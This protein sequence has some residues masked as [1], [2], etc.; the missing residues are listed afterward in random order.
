MTATRTGS[1]SECES[2]LSEIQSLYT[3]ISYTLIPQG[4]DVWQITVT[5]KE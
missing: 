4:N 5:Y 1:K 2:F 3:V